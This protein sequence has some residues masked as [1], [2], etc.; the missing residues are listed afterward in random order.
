MVQQMCPEMI[1]FHFVFLLTNWQRVSLCDAY[2][3]NARARYLLMPLG[4][5]LIFFLSEIYQDEREKRNRFFFETKNIARHVLNKLKK[6][7]DDS[8]Q[9]Q[10]NHLYK[11]RCGCLQAKRAKKILQF[12]F[13]NRF[14]PS[15]LFSLLCLAFFRDFLQKK[16]N[17]GKRDEEKIKRQMFCIKHIEM[18]THT[19][20]HTNEV[21]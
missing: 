10:E 3:G 18:Y 17:E 2:I 7:T 4:P 15:L 11:H 9:K 21:H 6:M 8:S 14:G 20:I 1:I 5:I 16:R 12:C 13:V 19:H